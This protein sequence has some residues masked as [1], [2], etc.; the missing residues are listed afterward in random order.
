MR[1]LSLV[2]LLLSSQVFF[3]QTTWTGSVDND[4]HKACNWSTGSIPT[5]SDDVIIPTVTTYPVVSGNAHC[6]TLTISSAAANTVTVQSSLGAD[7]CISSTNG[8]ACATVLT[9]NGGCAIPGAWFDPCNPSPPTG[10][11]SF[12]SYDYFVCPGPGTSDVWYNNTGATITLTLPNQPGYS[13]LP[14]NPVVIP[15]NTSVNISNSGGT[16]CVGSATF[17]DASWTSSDGGSGLVS[18][19]Y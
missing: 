11:F 1:I 13:W 7:L 5:I 14:S 12:C 10:P 15:P 8:G 6:R 16:P 19:T 2:S 3:A 17:G 9:D 18:I 4:W